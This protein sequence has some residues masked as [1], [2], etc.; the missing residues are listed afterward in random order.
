MR[1]SLVF[2]K[3][4]R[5]VAIVLTAPASSLSGLDAHPLRGIGAGELLGLIIAVIGHQLTKLIGM[6][7]GAIEGKQE[8]H[9]EPKAAALNKDALQLLHGATSSNELYCTLRSQ[10]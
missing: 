3:A 8:G 6:L 7:K 5:C 9:E 4:N 2:P 1:L 10:W